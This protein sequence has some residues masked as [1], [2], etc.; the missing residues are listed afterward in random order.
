MVKSSVNNVGC[1]TLFLRNDLAL[2][3]EYNFHLEIESNLKKIYNSK[4]FVWNDRKV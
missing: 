3:A 1:F 4:L 2:D